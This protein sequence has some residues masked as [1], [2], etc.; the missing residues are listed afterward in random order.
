MPRSTGNYT[1]VFKL[2]TP[3]E[4]FINL[5]RDFLLIN[6]FTSPK[7][8]TTCHSIYNASDFPKPVDIAPIRPSA[9]PPYFIEDLFGVVN[10]ALLN[11]FKTT[12]NSDFYVS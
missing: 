8:Y 6:F 9:N 4:V 2:Q 12:I 11:I 3:Y 7:T 5:K 10:L 1:A